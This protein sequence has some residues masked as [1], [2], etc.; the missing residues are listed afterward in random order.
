MQ[1]CASRHAVQR[2]EEDEA[3]GAAGRRRNHRT[4]SLKVHFFKKK[5][6]SG[7]QINVARR[8]SHP[9]TVARAQKHKKKNVMAL[10]TKWNNV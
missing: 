9:Q 3:K 8:R 6:F 7:K 4:S 5:M 1:L 10:Q 2:R